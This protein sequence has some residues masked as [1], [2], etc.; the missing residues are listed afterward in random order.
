MIAAF[1]FVEDADLLVGVYLGDERAQR[2][3]LGVV[4]VGDLALKCPQERQGGV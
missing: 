3:E 4:L 1:H 2:V